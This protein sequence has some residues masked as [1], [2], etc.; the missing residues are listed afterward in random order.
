MYN[1]VILMGRL[2]ADP[3]LKTTQT[4]VSVCRFRIAVDRYAKPGEEKQADF[5]QIQAWRNTAEFVSRYFTKGKPIHIE[6]RLQNNNYTDQNGVKH[7][8]MD[9]IADSV[10][11]C[12]DRAGGGD[13]AAQQ[14][15]SGANGNY[16]QTYTPSA[17][18]P[19]QSAQG[20]QGQN[21]QIALGDLGGFEE[22]LS[23]GVVPF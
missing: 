6:G 4:G 20:A 16:R 2:V 18:S 17:N 14:P 7:Y 19:L 21:Q 10:A 9:V 3:E 5:I 22:I 1:R 11:F 15:Y 8:S 13:T 12:G 23:D